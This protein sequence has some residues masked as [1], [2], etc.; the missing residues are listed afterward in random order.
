MLFV[1]H[2]K[3][4]RKHC[5]QFLLRVKMAPSETENNAYAKF[6]GNKQRALWYVLVFSRVVN[7]PF[8]SCLCSK[9]R[10]TAKPV[11]M[12]MS[13]NSLAKKTRFHRKGFALSL[14][15]KVRVFGSR[16]W[17]VGHLRYIK[18]QHDSVSKNKLN[19]TI[20]H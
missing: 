1:C 10:L 7:R 16:K 13:F 5:L 15:L 12:K 3:I 6:W 20:I 11:S 18:I 14:V 2:P 4:L 19:E 17:P 9:A 8:S